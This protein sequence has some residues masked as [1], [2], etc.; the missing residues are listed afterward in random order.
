MCSICGLWR[1]F[2]ARAC[3]RPPPPMTNIFINQ[4]VNDKSSA[5]QVSTLG[6]IFSRRV[7]RRLGHNAVAHMHWDYAIILIVLAMIVPWRSRARVRALL[8]A[9][10]LDSQ[11]RIG[12]YF[13]TIVFQ[14]ALSGIIFWRWSAHGTSFTELGFRLPS[15]PRATIAAA[16]LSTML[17]LNQVFGIRR[18]ASL[19]ADKRGLVAQLAERLLPRTR[20]EVSAAIWLVLSVAICEEFIYRGFIEVLFQQIFSSTWSGA[21]ISA[22]FF[23][24]AHIYQGRRGVLT[25]FVVG[26][27]FSAVRLW[28]GSLWPSIL[29]HFAVDFA[30][31]AASSRLLT[32][33]PKR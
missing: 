6:F 4:S 11:E 31:G 2:H 13:S 19:P 7:A 33:A 24:L 20:A 28:S 26:L 21:V 23:A 5:D 30:A 8:Q 27:V 15:L 10:T 14:W 16:G 1:N 32:P 18:L 17:V 29:I 9:P 22:V 3:S 25:T 12:L